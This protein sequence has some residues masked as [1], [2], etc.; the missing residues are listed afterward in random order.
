MNQER[1]LAEQGKWPLSPAATLARLAAIGAIMLGRP[2]RSPMSAAG[3]RPS[4]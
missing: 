3:F 1:D 4:V 2:Q